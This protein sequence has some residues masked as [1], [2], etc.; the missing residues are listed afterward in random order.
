MNN[1]HDIK[2]AVLGLGHVGLPTALGFADLGWPVIGI[3]KDTAKTER[4]SRGEVPFYEVGVEELLRKHLDSGRF[5]LES[6]VAGATQKSDV[7]FVCVDTPQ[8]ENGAPDLSM[9][10]A[11]ARD[12]A[13]HISEYKLIVEKST[14]PVQTAHRI[15]QSIQRYSGDRQ[16]VLSSNGTAPPFDVAVNPEF[17]RE[18]L[19]VHDFFHPDRIVLGV[20]SDKAAD[21]L[22]TIYQPLLDRMDSSFE[23]TVIVTDI[24]TAEVT[25][26]A[27]NAFLAT[28][29]SF[30]N[31]VAE[32]CE[33]TGADIGDVSKG[34]GMDHRIGSSYLRAGV[35]YGGSCLPKDIRAFNWIASQ[36]QVEFGLLREVERINSSMIDRFIIKLY[37]TLWVLKGKTL[38]VWG[39]S[40]KPGTDDVR[41]A[42]SLSIVR[43]L[44]DEGSHLRMYDPQAMKV[45]EREFAADQEN[46]TYCKSAL[47]ATDGAE[48][49]LIL[50]EWREFLDVDLN[51][52]RENMVVPVIVDGRNL[53]EP[54]SLRTQ[55]FEYHSIGRP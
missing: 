46:V 52:V 28:K 3:D 5:T 1:N 17:L 2:I 4:I 37:K 34:I 11:V 22:K 42:P 21:L 53:M 45:F 32:L 36:N 39:L 6:D 41:D 16:P 51:R 9:V 26:H 49:L 14:S 18:G 13:P 30:I 24:N 25:K 7:F 12:I 55:G 44:V 38:A 43:R 50:T 15:K 33:A 48:A 31:M 19:A 27:S 20:D 8:R 40:F 10:E 29:L 35:G 54:E 23:D 47:E